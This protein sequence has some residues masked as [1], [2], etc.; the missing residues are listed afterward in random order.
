M[1]VCYIVCPSIL[2]I[3]VI[4]ERQIPAYIMQQLIQMEVIPLQEK[5]NPFKVVIANKEIPLIIC[6]VYERMEF[7]A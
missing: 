6:A 2:C 1:R 7:R 5:E 4:S 3:V